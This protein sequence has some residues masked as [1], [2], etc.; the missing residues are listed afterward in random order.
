MTIRFY[1]TNSCVSGTDTKTRND[2]S[3]LRGV[4]TSEAQSISFIVGV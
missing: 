2:L 4:M 1:N 3:K